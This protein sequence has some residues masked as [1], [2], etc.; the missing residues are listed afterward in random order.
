MALL[1]DVE[2][3]KVKVS[4]LLALLKNKLELT[5]TKPFKVVVPKVFTVKL[6]LTL[7]TL[8]KIFV[9]WEVILLTLKL[10]FIVKL[11]VKFVEVPIPI[12][13]LLEEIN[14]CGAVELLLLLALRIILHLAWIKKLLE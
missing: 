5:L 8:L 3:L 10:P 14:K 12:N 11:L 4:I 13:P 1:A 2:L 7:T 9:P 6:E